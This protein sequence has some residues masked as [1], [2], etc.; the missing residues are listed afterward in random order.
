MNIN[1]LIAVARRE[2]VETVK[3]KAFLLGILLMPVIIVG[4]IFLSAKVNIEAKRPAGPIRVAILDGTNRVAAEM[5]RLADRSNGSGEPSLVLEKVPPTGAPDK[6]LEPL[7]QRVRDGSLFGVMEIPANAIQGGGQCNFHIRGAGI[8][9]RPYRVQHLLYEAV[10]NI[11]FAA[12][13]LD[14][15]RIEELSRPV[16]INQRDIRVQ[17][18]KPSGNLSKMAGVM[19]P[20]AFVFLL[21]MGVFGISQALLTNVIEEKSS[22]VVE[23]LLA[24]LSPFELMTGKILGM[25][26]VGLTMVVLWASAGYAAAVYNH[27]QHLVQVANVGQFILYYVLGFL[28]IS[29]I[30]AAIGSACNTLK[31]AQPLM[32]PLALLLAVPMMFWMQIAGSPNST[33]AVALSAVPPLTPF[34]MMIRLTSQEASVPLWQQVAAPIWLAFWMVVTMW[35]AGRIF[36]TGLLMYGKQPSLRE[37]ARWVRR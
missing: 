1:R 36:R 5:I 12:A 20:F 33:L 8:D 26:G 11:R 23:V 18:G 15:R 24:A 19:T 28:L 21:F 2:Y 10:K 35:A 27:V 14:P 9:D 31:E 25:A 3:T 22:R 34:L 32:T 4:M 37:L 6:N 16:S 17:S 13:G 7:K 29:S 30:L